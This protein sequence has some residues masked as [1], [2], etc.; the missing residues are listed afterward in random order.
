MNLASEDG[1]Q[2]HGKPCKTLFGC[3]LYSAHCRSALHPAATIWTGRSATPAINAAGRIQS[4]STRS[5]GTRKRTSRG[6]AR[7]AITSGPLP[8]AGKRVP[9]GSTRSRIRRPTSFGVA[10]RSVGQWNLERSAPRSPTGLDC[11]LL[12]GVSAKYSNCGRERKTGQRSGGGWLDRLDCRG[13]T[14]EQSCSHA[15]TRKQE[16]QSLPSNAIS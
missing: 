4:W 12:R 2:K 14:G 7:I 11:R 1:A 16:N 15:L 8:T 5:C 3:W 6:A 13:L 9:P 10:L